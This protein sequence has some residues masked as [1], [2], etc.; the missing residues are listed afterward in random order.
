MQFRVAS[1]KVPNELG[2]FRGMCECKEKEG[3]KLCIF[4]SKIFKGTE[5]FPH[6]QHL[7][8]IIIIYSCIRAWR[9]G[10]CNLSVIWLIAGEK[11]TLR[12]CGTL[13]P[14]N[15]TRLQSLGALKVNH[16]D[17][18]KGK[19][20]TEAFAIMWHILPFYRRHPRKRRHSQVHTES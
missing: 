16:I 20:L 11:I 17:S 7:W 19:F 2:G 8:A 3:Y 6:S 13:S 15:R 4:F 14:K 10:G 12:Y 9:V 18:Y 5:R 1:C